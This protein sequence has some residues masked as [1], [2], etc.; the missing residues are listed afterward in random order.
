MPYEVITLAALRRDPGFERVLLRGLSAEDI[1][2]FIHALA[3]GAPL[4][5]QAGQLAAAI[6]RET[7]GNRIT[8]YN[9]CYTKLLRAAIAYSLYY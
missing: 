4:D 7:E 3:Q 2:A 6:Q 9:V 5:E 1:L 8:S